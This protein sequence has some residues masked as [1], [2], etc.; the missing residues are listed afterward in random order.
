MEAILNLSTYK[1]VVDTRARVY[2]YMRVCLKS[3]RFTVSIW[4]TIE[5]GKI[6]VQPP[7]P[8]SLF[9][10]RLLIIGL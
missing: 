5:Q 6:D 7:N 4:S 3:E 9:F 10:C 8:I 1:Y 2:N